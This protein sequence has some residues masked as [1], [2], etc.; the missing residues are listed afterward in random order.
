MDPMSGLN[1]IIGSRFYSGSRSPTAQELAAFGL[2]IGLYNGSAA[3]RT[4]LRNDAVSAVQNMSE[5]CLEALANK[6]VTIDR[7]RMTNFARGLEFLDVSLFG[8]FT[9]SFVADAPKRVS[10]SSAFYSGLGYVPDALVLNGRGGWQTNIVVYDSAL[11]ALAQWATLDAGTSVLLIHELLHVYF[12]KTD[13][14][15]ASTMGLPAN[16]TKEASQSITSFLTE[17]HCGEKP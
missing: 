14:E 12:Q 2:F 15:L 1:G 11:R 16:S 5:T 17:N 3:D 9:T 13:K 10:M 4:K 7:Q 6:D 8:N